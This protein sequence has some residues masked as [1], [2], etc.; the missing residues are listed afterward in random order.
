MKRL[1][2][3]LENL[4]SILNGACEKSTI[5]IDFN[6]LQT[7]LSRI[8][9]FV[10]NT[11]IK[12]YV[13]GKAT[14]RKVAEDARYEAWLKHAAAQRAETNRK[15]ELLRKGSYEDKAMTFDARH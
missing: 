14:R 12:S 1:I 11:S 6:N 15:A 5:Q 3:Q 10:S 13:D 4:S 2:Q 9:E 7:T 8:V